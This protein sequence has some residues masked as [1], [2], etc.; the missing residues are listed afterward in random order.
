MSLLLLVGALARLKAVIE[1]VRWRDHGRAAGGSRGLPGL[2]CLGPHDV[3][4]YKDGM[5]AV[6][7]TDHQRQQVVLLAGAPG[8]MCQSQGHSILTEP[9]PAAGDP[10]DAVAAFATVGG[11]HSRSR[12][13]FG[14]CD[15]SRRPLAYWLIVRPPNAPPG[16]PDHS[17]PGLRGTPIL[18]TNRLAV[19]YFTALLCW[20]PCSRHPSGAARCRHPPGIS[21]R[22]RRGYSQGVIIRKVLGHG[23]NQGWVTEPPAPGLAGA[24]LRGPI[25]R[26]RSCAN[27]RNNSTQD[28]KS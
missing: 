25:P 4:G 3:P 19:C 17:V 16:L 20:T 15:V 5:L 6:D 21:G 12:A 26:C 1:V 28:A 14:C 10:T 18:Y 9:A 22:I 7:H 23:Q 2:P 11:C 13:T 24:R 8:R 27:A